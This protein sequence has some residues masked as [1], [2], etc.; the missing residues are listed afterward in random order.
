MSYQAW[1]AQM[2]LEQLKAQIQEYADNGFEADINKAAYDARLKTKHFIERT[3]PTTAFSG[4]NLIHDDINNADEI[5]RGSFKIEGGSGGNI[6]ANIYSNYFARWY[7]TGA[8][9]RTIRYGKRKGQKGTHYPPRGAYY[10]SNKQAIEE[11]Y[12][13][14]ILDYMKSNMS[15][16]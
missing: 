8:Y 7:N 5:I 9:G 3:H 11:F 16:Q 12:S 1:R 6:L 2:E 14:C 4:K 13:K 15:F 10:S